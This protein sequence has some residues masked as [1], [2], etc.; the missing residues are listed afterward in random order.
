MM[1]FLPVVRVKC[2]DR[3]I[4]AAVRAEHGYR[5]T[6]II[7]SANP[8]AVARLARAINTT[9]VVHNGASIAAL[10]HGSAGFHSH[11][12]ATPTGEGI[13]TPMTFTRQRMITSVGPLRIY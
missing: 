2:V 7:H 6:A 1:P 9:I 13:T 11:S 4:E 3:A 10:G 5:H 8:E 12:I